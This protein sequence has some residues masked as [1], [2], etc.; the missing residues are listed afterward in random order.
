V[1]VISAKIVES[2]E[3]EEGRRVIM[4]LSAKADSELAKSLTDD[5]ND[6]FEGLDIELNLKFK[7]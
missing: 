2:V 5:I 4:Q 6:A 3:V 1:D 7:D